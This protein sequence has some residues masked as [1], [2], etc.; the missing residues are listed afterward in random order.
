MALKLG[1]TRINLLAG[2]LNRTRDQTQ[3]SR[4]ICR[5]VPKTRIKSRKGSVEGL[6]LG[7]LL[8]QDGR[9][10]KVG[11]RG[12]AHR[13]DTISYARNYRCERYAEARDFDDALEG[14]ELA[15]DIKSTAMPAIENQI[16]FD[17]DF[18][19]LEIASGT[20]TAANSRDSTNITLAAGE[21]WDNN[22]SA[23]SLPV[24]HL[25]EGVDL[26][27]ADLLFLGTRSARALC[28]NDQLKSLVMTNSKAVLPVD[29]MVETLMRHLGLSRVVIG[30]RIYNAN[31]AHQVLS[32]AYKFGDVAM[33]SKS[34]N[35][36]YLPWRERRWKETEDEET[37][38]NSVI[39]SEWC[40][41]IVADPKLTVHYTNTLQ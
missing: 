26:T 14:D 7:S 37:E 38:V 40:D 28:R 12:K 13:S 36:L 3:L 18:M 24:D 17:I 15:E 6:E 23:T 21:E 39:A 5:M 31:G 1:S 19:L 41:I 16:T 10:S 22:A 35:L 27:G 32:L 29:E 2:D 30:Q 34:S 25:E 4:Q 33:L 8:P 9:P 11:D 20:G